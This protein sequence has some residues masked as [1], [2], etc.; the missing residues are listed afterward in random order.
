MLLSLL[1]HGRSQDQLVVSMTEGGTLLPEFLASG[2]KVQSLGMKRGLPDP[3]AISRL[4]RLLTDHRPDVVQTWM[5]HADLLGGL[6]ARS[7]PVV[8]SIHA[9]DIERAGLRFTTRMTRTLCARLS[10][11]LPERIVYCAESAARFHTSLG[12]ATDRAAVIPNGVDVDRF[13]PD[14]GAKGSLLG[15]LG[16]PSETELVGVVARFHPQ[17]D[18]RTFARAAGRL[19]A[20]RPQVHLVLCGRDVDPTNEELV[21]WL[22]EEGVYE[23]SHLLG[24]RSDTPRI[25]A[26]LD[27]LVL[28]SAYGEAAPVVL[29]EAMSCATPCVVT[30]VGDSARIVG[31]TGSVVPTGRAQEIADAVDEHLGSAHEMK[32]LRASQARQRVIDNYSIAACAAAYA[33]LY[34]ELVA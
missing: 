8:W 7:T 5:Y 24:E 4:R 13:V 27:V 2:A 19:V 12:Y 32:V 1:Q 23:Q 20:R 18:H 29:M 3:R 31:T 34:E 21:G 14:D 16:L 17:K 10:R 26:A 33:G 28:S 11:R 30:D 9:V 6:A 15:E 22:R 25:L